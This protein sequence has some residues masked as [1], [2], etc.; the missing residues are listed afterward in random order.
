ME[1]WFDVV[2]ERDEVVGRERRSVVHSRNLL[3]RAVHVIAFNDAGAVF[4]QM[5][6]MKK[7][8]CPGM[9]G[10]SAAGHLES[11]EGYAE[12]ARREFREELGIEP[13]PFEELFKLPPSPQTGW[14]HVV[15]YQCRADGP[16]VLDPEEIDRGVWIAPEDLTRAIESGDSSYTPSLGTVWRGYL[17]LRR[18]NGRP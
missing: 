16:F 7:D 15:V 4:L 5:R 11:G 13:P 6:S 1:E 2:D 9:W 18:R 12:A 10:T 8:Q 3:H 14:E 17:A